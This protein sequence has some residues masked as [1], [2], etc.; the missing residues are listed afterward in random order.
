MSFYCN[1]EWFQPVISNPQA[2]VEKLRKYECVIG[3]D[4]SPYDN[5]PQVLQDYQIWL[6]L[7]NTYYY[8]SKGLKV[9][10]NVRLGNNFT[11][12]SLKAYPKHTIIAVGT[13]GFTKN[14]K[15]VIF[16]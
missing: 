3:M 1:D 9:I 2:Y 5:M 13:N 14:L 11:L 6:N 7:A 12:D 8:G 15:T 4:C 10:P 16:L